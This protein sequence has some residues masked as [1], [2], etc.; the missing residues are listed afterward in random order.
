MTVDT[1]STALRQRRR[2]LKAL[3]QPLFPRRSAWPPPSHARCPASRAPHLAPRGRHPP[4]ADSRRHP[5]S[6]ST[7][8]DGSPSLCP[9][10]GAHHLRFFVALAPWRPSCIGPCISAR[11]LAAHA[12]GLRLLIWNPNLCAHVYVRKLALRPTGN[13]VLPLMARTRHVHQRKLGHEHGLQHRARAHRPAH[14]CVMSSSAFTIESEV[15]PLHRPAVRRLTPSAALQFQRPH[16]IGCPSRMAAH[17]DVRSPPYPPSGRPALFPAREDLL[18]AL[19]DMLLQHCPD[20]AELTLCSFSA[21]HRT[22]AVE[23]RRA[24]L[25]VPARVPHAPRAQHR[26]APRMDVPAL[27]VPRG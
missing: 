14:S 16:I 27:D 25:A 5:R 20:L 3:L 9:S 12:T 22:F 17:K 1:S 26:I 24:R 11:A 4:G 19:W 13:Y 10:S 18:E 23:H 8:S 2:S 7:K 6:A 21:G 15:R